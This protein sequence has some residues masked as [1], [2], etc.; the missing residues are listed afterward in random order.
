MATPLPIRIVETF[1]DRVRYPVFVI[2]ISSYLP[3]MLLYMLFGDVI[4]GPQPSIWGNPLE[5]LGLFLLLA[6]LP[7]YLLM[8]FIVAVRSNRVSYVALES[9]VDAEEKINFDRY[10]Y[11]SY[12]P[13][14]IALGI[15]NA[16][17]SNITW[18]TL[19][20]DSGQDGFVASICLVFGQLVAWGCIGLILFFNIQ[21]GM[22]LSRLGKLVR[23]DL[24]NLNSFGRAGLNGFLWVAGA[25]ALTTLQAL[26]GEFRLDNYVDALTVGIPAAIVLIFLPIWTVHSRTRSAK[27]VL[28]GEIGEEIAQSSRSFDN[29]SLL[30]LNA[31]IQRR[32]QIL[33]LRNWP[34]DLSIFHDSFFS[35]SYR[36]WLGRGV[37]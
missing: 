30:R 14:A 27:T 36:H 37:R 12:W 35:C 11:A 8:C 25:L 10:R 2:G 23:I 16:V 17:A 6:A 1:I 31:L 15:I 19:I 29:D 13:L 26:D 34:M 9:L 22:A 3:L 4:P 32:D 20:F 18:S 28:I 5:M 33:S 7:A 24:F 21:Q